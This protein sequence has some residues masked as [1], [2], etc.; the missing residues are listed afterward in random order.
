MGWREWFRKDAAL[1]LRPAGQLALTAPTDALASLIFPADWAGD[2]P[3]TVEEALAVPSVMRAVTVVAAPIS[4]LPITGAPAWLTSS[5]ASGALTLQNVLFLTVQDLMLH[6]AGD[7]LW[8]VDRDAAGAITRAWYVRRDAWHVDLAGAVTVNGVQIPAAHCVYF[9]RGLP[10][11][12]KTAR[13]TIRQYRA[14]SDLITQA[15]EMPHP[16]A[17]LKETISGL[18]LSPQVID[19]TQRN[20]AAMLKAKRGG[21]AWLPYGIAY[22][23]IS[24]ELIPA[25][26]EARNAVRLDIANFAGLDPAML[27]G[28]TG[29]SNT[30]QNALQGDREYVALTIKQFA[31]PIINRL[32]QL[33]VRGPGG[34]MSFDY[35]G[36]EDLARTQSAG[37]TGNPRHQ[38]E[39]GS[40]G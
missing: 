6:P 32:N 8:V 2:A 24:S 7:A 23:V 15:G 11:L 30:Y 36:L 22:E 35:T 5:F 9:S 38:E 3:V 21:V 34:P 17:V 37:N 4:E 31:A 26:T 20:F 19:E 40:N 12:C 18:G 33:D 25:L 28:A 14:L 1:A 16:R 13:A 29:S 10:G 27:A 39:E